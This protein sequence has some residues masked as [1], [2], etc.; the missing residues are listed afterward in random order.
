MKNAYEIKKLIESGVPGICI[1]S[2]EDL[3]VDKALIDAS[4]Q[5]NFGLP[6]EW[7]PGYGW[8]NFN[9]KQPYSIGMKAGPM[10]LASDLLHLQDGAHDIRNRIIVIKDANLALENN[11]HSIARLKQLLLKIQKNHQGRAAVVLVSMNGFIAST[12]EPLIALLDLPLP[13]TDNILLLVK[14][15]AE[16]YN[17]SQK[18]TDRIAV[19]CGGLDEMGIGQVLSM[20]RAQWRL[21]RDVTSENIVDNLLGIIS[22][23]K[24]RHIAKSGVL[25]LVDVSRCSL[26]DVGGLENLKD[27]LETRSTIMDRLSEAH[28][29]GI[30]SPKGALIVGI[31]GC[32]KSLIAKGAAEKFKLPLLRLDI[33]SLLGKYVGESEHNMRKALALAE[34]SSPCVLWIDEFEK[35][36][37][38]VGGQG[39]SEVMTRLLGFFLTWMQDKSKSVFVIATANDITTLPAELLRRG[40]FDEIFYVDFPTASERADIIKI[41]IKKANGQKLISGDFDDF[42]DALAAD[43]DD[44]TGADIQGMVN[45]A[46]EN[47]FLTKSNGPVTLDLEHFRQARRE[48]VP[49]KVSLKKKISEYNEKLSD[50]QLKPAS[51]PD[52]MDI[53]FLVKYAESVNVIERMQAAEAKNC[54][55]EILRKLA[56]D[57]EFSVRERVF[58]NKKCPED[59]LSIM[60]QL[61]VDECHSQSGIEFS[62]ELFNLACCHANMSQQLLASVVLGRSLEG[63]L[64]RKIAALD[65]ISDEV[66]IALVGSATTCA[67]DVRKFVATRRNVSKGLQAKIVSACIE[68]HDHNA[69]NMILNNEAFDQS[70]I[71]A[72]DADS[73][74][75][76]VR[77]C[78]LDE[79]LMLTVAT[80][81]HVT[82]SLLE[83]L[84]F[85]KARTQYSNSMAEHMSRAEWLSPKF[86]VELAK[87]YSKYTDIGLVYALAGKKNVLDSNTDVMRSKILINLCSRSSL[88]EEAQNFIL[89]CSGEE[90]NGVKVALAAN[91]CATEK[92][93]KKLAKSPFEDVRIALANNL[94]I[95]VDVQ[96]EFAAHRNIKTKVA[97]AKNPTICVD[98]RAILAMDENEEVRNALVIS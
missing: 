25:D 84:L 95:C 22:L 58:K 73:I 76:F 39:G 55:P 87:Q 94:S 78:V 59:V 13:S 65:H 67:S 61:D 53:A 12:L 64:L 51:K 56:S 50:Y 35:A 85:E 60:I 82:S 29:F 19:A 21:Q 71:G 77:C 97:L 7:N 80:K 89:Y 15:F 81:V 24:G 6:L 83:S 86:E 26:K 32:G 30:Q 8:V 10:D 93:Q 91:K 33:G 36:F 74:E 62:T 18:D 37:A 48:V 72:L 45:I 27:W 46:L 14:D 44:Y 1:R 52:G 3:R 38:G 57:K 47:A 66:V 28:A 31:P 63:E 43:C 17:L 23:E 92:V 75:K 90:Q 42:V 88:C 54:P 16:E 49:L 41:H 20:Q 68:S 40:R 96:L 98:A 2:A 79:D 70:W 34:A 11:A 4:K 69:I 9:T 5:M